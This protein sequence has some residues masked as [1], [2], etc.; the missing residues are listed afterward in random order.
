MGTLNTTII[1]LTDTELRTEKYSERC[2]KKATKVK[3]K[4]KEE[5]GREAGKK[6]E[7]G[8][9][10]YQI[11]NHAQENHFY[12]TFVT[13]CIKSSLGFQ[14]KVKN[15][16]RL[17]SVNQCQYPT[18]LPPISGKNKNEKTR[19]QNIWIITKLPILY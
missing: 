6:G 18:F 14:D 11:W 9:Q 17:P 8:I 12:T 7:Y 10:L 3:K 15:H 1:C 5:E 2:Q 19:D 13:G 16:T 4:K